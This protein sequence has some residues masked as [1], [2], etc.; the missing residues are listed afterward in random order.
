MMKYN[1]HIFNDSHKGHHKPHYFFSLSFVN[2]T[3]MNMNFVIMYMYTSYI[4]V[5]TPVNC[6]VANI[7]NTCS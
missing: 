7:T 6:L 4:Y 1:G 3:L 2:L 5:Y